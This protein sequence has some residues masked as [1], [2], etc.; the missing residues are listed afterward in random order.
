MRYFVG[1]RDFD[2]FHDQVF[3]AVRMPLV[4]YDSWYR[5]LENDREHAKFNTTCCLFYILVLN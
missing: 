5:M 1:F 4:L 3:N 2:F